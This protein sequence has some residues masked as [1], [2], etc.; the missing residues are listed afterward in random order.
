MTKAV[1]VASEGKQ[2]YAT[3]TE[4]VHLIARRFGV[5]FVLDLSASSE[6]A[7][8]ADWIDEKENSLAQNWAERIS[9]NPPGEYGRVNCAW[10]NP[11]FKRAAP[12]MEKC[13][14]ESAKGM[15]IVSLTLSSMGSN[16]YRDHVEGKAFS[17]ILRDRVTFVGCNDPYTKELMVTLWGFGMTGL[18]FWSWKK[19]LPDPTVPG[20]GN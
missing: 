4:L 14:A 11:P 7:K 8:C 10:L 6:N 17:L 15:R 2:D 9:T 3:P 16:W 5:S 19:D 12:W 13:A 18:G 1:H 20:R